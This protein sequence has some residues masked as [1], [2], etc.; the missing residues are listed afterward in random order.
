MSKNEFLALLGS[1]SIA[2]SAEEVQLL[3]AHFSAAENQ[4]LTYQQYLAILARTPEVA[5]VAKKEGGMI[6]AMN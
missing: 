6:H 5:V 2:V 1:L 4:L 3:F